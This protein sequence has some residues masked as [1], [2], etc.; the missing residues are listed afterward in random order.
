MIYKNDAICRI[1]YEFYIFITQL[2]GGLLIG[3]GLYAFV[4]KW[5]TTGSIRMEN[6]YD[7][8][9]N[10]SL[11]MVIAGGVVFVV[12]FAGCIGALRENTCLLKFVSILRKLICTPSYL[13]SCLI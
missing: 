7:V 13:I 9:L 6:V 3:V 5:Q 1:E 4:E 2:F 8:V 10:I 11:V 12:S